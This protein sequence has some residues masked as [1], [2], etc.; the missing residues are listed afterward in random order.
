[1]REKDFA[2]RLGSVLLTFLLSQPDVSCRVECV[3][4]PGLKVELPRALCSP[5]TTAW[6]RSAK[7]TRRGTGVC[8]SE[9]I[10]HH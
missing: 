5:R 8:A 4:G 3:V 7:V 9:L 2:G 6:H 1:M 10:L